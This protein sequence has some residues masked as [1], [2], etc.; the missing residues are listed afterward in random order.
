[1]L[2]SEKKWHDVVV[3]LRDQG[4]LSHQ[5]T[6]L[7]YWLRAALELGN[8]AEIRRSLK[9]IKRIDNAD[10][11]ITI[12]NVMV[13]Q[14]RP[15]HAAEVLNALPLDYRSVR[16]TELA[17]RIIKME[18]DRVTRR[19][20]DRFLRYQDAAKRAGMVLHRTPGSS[21][22]ATKLPSKVTIVRLTGV[23]AE[24]EER[25]ART[26]IDFQAALDTERYPA[27][28]EY[29]NVFV[30]AMGDVWGAEGVIFLSSG[31]NIATPADPEAVPVLD[32]ACSFAG[33]HK[34][35]F[36]WLVR[37]LGGLNWRLAPETPDCPILI[38]KEQHGLALEA[39]GALGVPEDKIIR[40]E[41]TIFCRRLYIGHS[42][43]ATMARRGAYRHV[44]DKLIALADR[45]DDHATP[46]RFYISRRD[47]PRRSMIGEPA[48]EQELEALGIVPI[49]LSTL[50]LLDK[51]RLFR[52]AELVVGA[53]GAGF[54]HLIFAKPNLRVVEIL[55]IPETEYKL[56]GVQTCFMRLS[57]VF[58]HR[59]TLVL[60]PM[61]P[62]T[63]E[64]SPDIDQIARVLAAS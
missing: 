59:H 54:S 42:T 31:R 10:H 39:L 41:D 28:T 44:N 19:R 45:D 16:V 35:Y 36:E 53:H 17:Q 27:V 13:R 22:P 12:A 33:R 50:S 52:N 5:P 18:R 8:E 26:H 37:R 58:G 57:I 64:W 63:T 1:M 61:H 14:M 47:S 46:R 60:Q 40:L 32:E 38:R 20:L 51:I 15:A 21:E 56:L 48:F 23:A 4:D 6:V 62:G 11:L 49:V 34:G 30:N 2:M 43:V 24:I 7:A 25:I 29:R 55:P 3:L 9:E